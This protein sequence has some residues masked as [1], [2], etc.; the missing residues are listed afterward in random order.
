MT[1]ATLHSQE[2]VESEL[3]ESSLTPVLTFK[4]I[5]L[6]VFEYFA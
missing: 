2:S 1:R 3:K 6:C 5:F 4:K